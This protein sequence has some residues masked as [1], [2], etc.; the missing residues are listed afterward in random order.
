M[1]QPLVEKGTGDLV[2]LVL[3]VSL[4]EMTRSCVRLRRSLS[5]S[6]KDSQFPKVGGKPAYC[7]EQQQSRT[8]L[9]SP[10]A[11]QGNHAS[12]F[13][14]AS[15]SFGEN[16]SLLLCRGTNWGIHPSHWLTNDQ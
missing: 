4:W 16:R 1:A 12:C 5:K 7:R 13:F 9:D 3:G 11:Y 8:G 2:M 10:V 6:C 14:G 15:P